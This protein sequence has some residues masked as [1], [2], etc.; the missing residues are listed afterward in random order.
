MYYVVD[1]NIIMKRGFENIDLGD[2][3]PIKIPYGERKHVPF[4][5]V[6][7]FLYLVECQ[8]ESN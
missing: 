1:N 8:Q 5:L 3:V 2:P 7:V 6:Q 4:F